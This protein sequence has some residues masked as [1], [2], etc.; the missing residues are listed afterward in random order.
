MTPIQAATHTDPYPCYERLRRH[1][2][3]SFDAELG[4]RIASDAQSV[5]AILEHPDCLVRPLDEPV[6]GY[7]GQGAAGD[8]FSRLMRMNE[9]AAH[10][11]PKRVMA[12]ALAALP[13]HA[14]AE[15]VE[16]AARQLDGPAGHL[17]AW[18]FTLPLCTVA[19]LIGFAGDQRQAV[20]QRVR[21]YVT[22]LSPLSD[23]VALRRADQAADQLRQAFDAVLSQ[24]DPRNGFL[25]Q[26]RAGCEAAG[27]H[28]RD[29][30]IANLI[31]LMSQACDA[32]AGLIGN[33]LIALRCSPEMIG[34]LRG[35]PGLLGEWVAEVAR[36]DSP[37]QNTRRFLARPCKVLGYALEA[38]DTVLVLL[39]SANRDARA[40]AAPDSF[41]LERPHRRT[42]SF[43]GGR[44]ECP[45][46]RLALGIAT[47]AVE[48]WLQQPAP[49]AAALR[50][51][52]QPSLNG[53]IPRFCV[54]E[55]AQR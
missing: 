28:D 29:A 51:H 54:D 18:M 53:R 16:E 46:Q 48:R 42:F 52:Y 45:G 15:A 31:G 21:E 10:L 2:G 37:V 49:S 13:A 20:A 4:L 38:G 36:H 22:C 3:L 8:I 33:A 41:V 55:E 47:Y 32:T 35:T 40:N 12:L 7:L 26:V 1:A 39:G 23:E 24:D 17:D 34:S 11:G 25:G 27:W 5:Q 30:L 44:H 6:P 14:I 19:A 9:G 43:G 50:W